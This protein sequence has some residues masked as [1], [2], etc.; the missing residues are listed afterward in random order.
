M[1]RKDTFV[2]GRNLN[3]SSEQWIDNGPNFSDRYKTVSDGW[4]FVEIARR[5]IESSFE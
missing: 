2:D 3:H 1:P 5:S 4:S